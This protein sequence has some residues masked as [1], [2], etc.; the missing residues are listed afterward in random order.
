MKINTALIFLPKHNFGGSQTG[1]C[2]RRVKEDGRDYSRL[3]GGR[4]EKQRH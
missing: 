4:F 3:I 1:P 2:T